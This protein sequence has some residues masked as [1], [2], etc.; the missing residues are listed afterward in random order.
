MT[1]YFDTSALV[2]LY[3]REPGTETA[4]DIYHSGDRIQ[5][6]ELARIEF[7]STV[8]RKLREGTLDGQ[9]YQAVVSRFGQD[10]LDRYE[11]LHFASMV[12]NET[13]RVLQVHGRNHPLRTLDA[14][15]IAFYHVYSED[16]TV[17]V[18]A[19]QRLV[20]VIDDENR[21]T[22]NPQPVPGA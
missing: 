11:V 3:H 16:D 13:E 20:A 1:C 17:F 10:L 21:P 14:I 12:V 18:C 6:L 22:M 4:L 19:D 5:I 7:L 2:K 9:A 15:Q 8:M